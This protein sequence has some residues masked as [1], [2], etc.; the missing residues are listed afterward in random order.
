MQNSVIIAFAE[1]I[2]NQENFADIETLYNEAKISAIFSQVL[3]FLNEKNIPLSKQELAEFVFSK[4]C[5]LEIYVTDMTQG[6]ELNREARGKDY[7]TNILSYPSEMPA[8]VLQILPSLP[9]GELVICHDVVVSQADEQGKTVNEHLSHL[10]VHGILHLLDFDHERGQAE[11]DEME[12]LE[13]QILQMM[14][15]SNPYE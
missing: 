9:L 13:I 7:A 5:E 8:S 14:G 10:I 15:I 12:D 1:S 6:H 4:P 2:I 3:S 11:Q